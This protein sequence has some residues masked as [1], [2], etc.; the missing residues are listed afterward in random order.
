M[1]YDLAAL[2]NDSTMSNNRKFNTMRDHVNTIKNEVSYF[3][4]IIVSAQRSR[5]DIQDIVRSYTETLKGLWNRI[6]KEVQSAEQVMI[7]VLRSAKH[8]SN[9]QFSSPVELTPDQVKA[10]HK[11]QKAVMDELLKYTG[12]LDENALLYNGENIRKTIN[13]ISFNHAALLKDKNI[14]KCFSRALPSLEAEFRYNER[15]FQ[16]FGTDLLAT[17]QKLLSLYDGLDLNRYK[18]NLLQYKTVDSQITIRN[19]IITPLHDD[20]EFIDSSLFK[21]TMKGAETND[22]IV[23]ERLTSLAQNYYE[24]NK[25]LVDISTQVMK[26]PAARYEPERKQIFSQIKRLLTSRQDKWYSDVDMILSADLERA[27]PV[28][29]QPP[30]PQM[31]G[32]QINAGNTSAGGQQEYNPGSQY[33]AQQGSGAGGQY[34][35]GMNGQAGNQYGAGAT[36]QYNSN[37]GGQYGAGAGGQNGAGTGQNQARAY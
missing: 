16:D 26:L 30:A 27:F 36:G 35:S 20:A 3:S 13:S 1:V 25:T 6:N 2:E 18:K 17:L 32:S 9:S 12:K 28:L 8:D 7:Q 5:P 29:P 14:N 11:S 10:A 24:Y 31:G 37:A 23:D 4:S 15:I 33:G 22:R 21:K 34:G 19:M